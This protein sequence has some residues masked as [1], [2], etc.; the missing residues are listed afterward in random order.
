MTRSDALAPRLAPARPMAATTK[1]SHWPVA[2]LVLACVVCYPLAAATLCVNPDGSAGCQKTIGAAVAAASPGDTVNV[3]AGTYKE[4]LNIFQPITLIGANAASTIIDATGLA[5]GIYVDGIDNP[6]LANVFISGFTVQNANFEGIL[7]TNAS[8]VTISGNIVTNNDKNIVL[9]ETAPAC[10][11]LPDFETGETFDCGEGIHLL[12]ASHSTV[13]NN[14]VHSNAGGILITDDT[15]AA[16]DNVV[17]GNTVTDNDFDCGITLASHPPAMV[18]GSQTALGVYNNHVI[19][20]QSLRNGAGG[21]GAGVGIFASAPGTAA[22]GNVVADNQISGNGI[23]GVSIHGH[24][25]GQNLNDNVIIGNTISNNGADNGDTPTPGP[26]GINVA[27]I[28]PISGMIIAGN[29]ITMETFDVAVN[30][31]GQIDVHRNSFSGAI[32]IL[33][34]GRGTVNADGNYWGCGTNPASLLGA[35]AGC[36][37][38]SGNVPVNSW[39]TAA[40][41]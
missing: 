36:A 11:G 7:V 22:Y 6:N 18:S 5:N 34:L 9:S 16:H 21:A 37:T 4:D 15:A 38:T 23:P 27:G 2:P 14:T 25:P 8:A 28:S 29:T 26:A 3:A 35:F 30:I 12:G 33:N 1:Q 17:T 19:G 31:P 41:Q 10:P 24:T 40:P 20:N 13:A 39:L 32:G